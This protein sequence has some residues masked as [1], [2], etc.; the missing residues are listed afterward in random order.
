MDK[1]IIEAESAL[2]VAIED[3]ITQGWN[4]QRC[5]TI[6]FS[7]KKCCALGALNL[8]PDVLTNFQVNG[9]MIGMSKEECDL[10][11]AGFDHISN[12]TPAS[13]WR[14]PDTKDSTWF[15]LGKRLAKK[16]VDKD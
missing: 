7:V 11:V 9:E 16:Y 4:I 2:T 12:D 1:R 5:S 14:H 13:T 6:R 3:A 15:S 10:F 8:N